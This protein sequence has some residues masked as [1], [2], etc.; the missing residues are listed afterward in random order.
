MF[1]HPL[2]TE[3]QSNSHGLS[4]ASQLYGN[5][6]RRTYSNSSINESSPMRGMPMPPPPT[7][8]MG[9]F[10]PQALQVAHMQS[11]HDIGASGPYLSDLVHGQEPLNA[12]GHTALS[13]TNEG[14]RQPKTQL[15]VR[16]PSDQLQKLILALSPPKPAETQSSDFTQMPPPPLPLHALAA[17]AGGNSQSAPGSSHQTEQTTTAGYGAALY[18]GSRGSSDV[19]MHT[20]CAYFPSCTSE[21]DSS[22]VVHNSPS[23]PSTS[24]KGRKEGSSPAKRKSCSLLCSLDRTD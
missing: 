12:L 9:H 23:C 24:I 10:D 8:A 7:P 6:H 22:L 21:D 16:L 15:E 14:H 19:S 3:V 13:H 5:A 2:R 17:K 20:G 18:S 11:L 4:A 1:E